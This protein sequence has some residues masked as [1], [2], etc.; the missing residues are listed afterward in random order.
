MKFYLINSIS[1]LREVLL[2]FTCVELPTVRRKTTYLPMRMHLTKNVDTL[3]PLTVYGLKVKYCSV[4]SLIVDVSSLDLMVNA[5]L[6]YLEER[7]S[8]KGPFYLFHSFT[9]PHAGGVGNVSLLN[10]FANT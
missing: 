7:A 9:T 4:P 10:S 3:I 6:Q 8:S 5:T 1:P 2:T